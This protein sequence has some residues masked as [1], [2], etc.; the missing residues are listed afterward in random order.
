MAMNKAV[1]RRSSRAYNVLAV[2][3]VIYIYSCL[4]RQ[5]NALILQ[6]FQSNFVKISKQIL[7]KMFLLGLSML[8][9]NGFHERVAENTKCA[10]LFVVFMSFAKTF[11][12]A[13]E[14]KACS[15]TVPLNSLHYQR[16]IS[17]ILVASVVH[18]YSLYLN[19]Q[20][21]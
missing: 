19:S 20:D 4:N 12:E 11:C 13:C 5:P 21:S 3:A 17:Q 15:S 9:L 2:S 14:T 18:N 1:R 16:D 10:A 8:A 7:R 6:D